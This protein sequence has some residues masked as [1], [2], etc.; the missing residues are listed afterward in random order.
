MEQK[1]RTKQALISSAE[2]MVQ[3]WDAIGKNKMDAAKMLASFAVRVLQE[4]L[5]LRVKEKEEGDV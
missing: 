2:L 4:E 3:A 1:E 5:Q